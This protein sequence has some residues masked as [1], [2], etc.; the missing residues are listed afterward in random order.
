MDTAL[1]ARLAS[2][3]DTLQK[4]SALILCNKDVLSIKEAAILLGRSEK[5][6]RN[7]LEQ[8]PHYRGGTG[9]VFKRKELEEWQC[10]KKYK[11]T[12]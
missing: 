7:R 9:I 10:Q 11:P 5:T 1:T 12:L 4:V 8:I 3:E 6:I 2:L